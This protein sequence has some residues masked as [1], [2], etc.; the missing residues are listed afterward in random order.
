MEPRALISANSTPFKDKEITDLDKT[1]HALSELSLNKGKSL[2]YKANMRL[3]F[4]DTIAKRQ[5][6]TCTA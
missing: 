4:Y 6:T 5:S 3:G 1:Q 2:S